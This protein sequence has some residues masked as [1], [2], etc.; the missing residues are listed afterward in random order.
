[1]RFIRKL[2]TGTEHSTQIVG[3]RD[4]YLSRDFREKIGERER[5]V[6]KLKR[7]ERLAKTKKRVKRV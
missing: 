6:R 1:M 5:A 4:V 2:L 7:E 3:K